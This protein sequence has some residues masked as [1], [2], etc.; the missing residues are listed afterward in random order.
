MK[1]GEF[2]ILFRWLFQNSFLAA[3]R[4]PDNSEGDGDDLNNDD[5]LFDPAHPFDPPAGADSGAAAGGDNDVIVLEESETL[6]LLPD[7]TM[8]TAPSTTAL[9]PP[10]GERWG[11][12]T[13][14]ACKLT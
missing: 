1:V 9:P 4:P 14:N 2:N 3:E 12:C 7:Q 11:S 6:L 8:E 13:N 5:F 10:E